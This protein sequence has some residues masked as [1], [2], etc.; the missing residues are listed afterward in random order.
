MVAAGHETAGYSFLNCARMTLVGAMKPAVRLH[1]TLPAGVR[2]AGRAS[3]RVRT[4]RG[5]SASECASAKDSVCDDPVC[6][7]SSSIRLSW[8]AWRADQRSRSPASATVG[9]P[10]RA[11]SRRGKASGRPHTS[12]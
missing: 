3:A 6:A 5:R 10:R 2:R 1:K 8:A 4:M 9:R 12:T 7:F 11:A